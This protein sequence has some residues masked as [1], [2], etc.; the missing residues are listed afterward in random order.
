MKS[1]ASTNIDEY[2]SSF[3]ENVQKIM[4]ELRRVIREAA[5]DAKEC[6][7]Y[8]MPA[9]EQNGILVYF[10]GFKNHIGF[11]PTAEGK[12]AFEEEL[13]KYKGGKGTV[14]FPLDRPIPYDLVRRIVIHRVQQNMAKE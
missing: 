9:F 4:Q 5:P 8:Q 6:I 3:P 7:S 11:F 12:A 2:I 10:A 14:Q 1:G 13:K